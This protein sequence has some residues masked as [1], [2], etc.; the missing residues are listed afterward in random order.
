[1][2]IY[3]SAI[4]SP[5]VTSDLVSYCKLPLLTIEPV[6]IFH[7][8]SFPIKHK[9]FTALLTSLVSTPY[10]IAT[11]LNRTSRGTNCTPTESHY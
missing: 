9:F 7:Q 10:S 4:L 5:F 6:E 3:L 11:S 8:L 2:M 1:M